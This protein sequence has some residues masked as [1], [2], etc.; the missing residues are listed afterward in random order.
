MKK[1]AVIAVA[2]MVMGCMT[3]KDAIEACAKSTG[4]AKCEC[5]HATGQALA[6]WHSESLTQRKA[7][8]CY[9]DIVRAGEVAK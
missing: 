6:S 2:L 5:L 4:V 7:V 8:E 9:A 1:S 3:S